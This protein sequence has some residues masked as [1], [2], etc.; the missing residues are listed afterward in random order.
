M[1][2]RNPFKDAIFVAILGFFTAAAALFLATEPLYSQISTDS[3]VK[4]NATQVIFFCA[5]ILLFAITALTTVFVL[6]DQETSTI[7]A[8]IDRQRADI[9]KHV[10][11]VSK[12][13]A[14]AT[15]LNPSLLND[16]TVTEL[17]EVIASVVRDTR[18]S[19]HHPLR[20]FLLISAKESITREKSR[21]IGSNERVFFNRNQDSE[22]C[23]IIRSMLHIAR[24]H[25]QRVHAVSI[26]DDNYIPSYFNFQDAESYLED[27]N[28][29]RVFV[30]HRA[31]LVGQGSLG[32]QMIRKFICHYQSAGLS[33]VPEFRVVAM[34]D[35][36]EQV[37][38][39]LTRSFICF[40][41]FASES[42]AL[43]G[44]DNSGHIIFNSDQ[45]EDRL[46]TLHDAL[47][48]A[49]DLSSML[50][51]LRELVGGVMVAER[52]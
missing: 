37:R 12:F 43:D 4:F 28:V 10:D 27:P 52:S 15:S 32:V 6:A 23:R 26:D 48:I 44:S 20:A 35:L 11:D 41:G 2:K 17:L 25:Q 5:A 46:R 13:T 3:P 9:L 7:N 47:W 22:R 45:I 19:S 21:L 40:A 18:Q 29:R 39:Q 49:E 51:S 14:A 24:H 38:I 31:S 33:R 1:A 30:I 34:D 36:P 16:E 42:Y 8:A 50:G